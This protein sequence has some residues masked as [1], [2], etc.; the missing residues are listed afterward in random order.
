MNPNAPARAML[1]Y[2]IH[3]FDFAPFFRPRTGVFRDST[4]PSAGGCGGSVGGGGGGGEEHE[5]KRCTRWSIRAR[6]GVGRLRTDPWI[7]TTDALELVSA[8]GQQ[9]AIDTRAHVLMIQAQLRRLK[10]W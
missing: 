3:F 1:L 6:L 10:E 7:G 8:S 4:D 2:L 9:I 5:D